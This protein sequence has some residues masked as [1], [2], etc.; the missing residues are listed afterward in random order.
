MILFYSNNKGNI[1]K[2]QSEHRWQCKNTPRQVKAGDPA[3]IKVNGQ[4]EITYLGVIDKIVDEPPDSDWVDLWG[5]G[6]VKAEVPTIHFRNIST[7]DFAEANGP[8]VFRYRRKKED[9]NE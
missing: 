5:S 4:E 6:I 1:Y 7:S 2:A 3:F 9:D 8:A